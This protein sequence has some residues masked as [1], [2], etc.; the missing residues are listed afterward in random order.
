MSKSQTALRKELREGIAKSLFDLLENDGEQVMFTKAN[1]IC[2]PCVDSENG[3]WFA[4]ITIEIPTGSRDDNEPFDAFA[5]A[6]EFA[7]KQKENAEKAL[8]KEKAKKEK[9]AR[10]EKLR[11]R[12]AE[13]ALKK[14]V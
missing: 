2:F 12:K 11:Q 14:E 8:A 4:R 13:I 7:L 1:Q 10:D 3:E 9:I 5:V 6:E